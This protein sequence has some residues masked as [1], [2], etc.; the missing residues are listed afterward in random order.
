[1]EV[2]GFLVELIFNLIPIYP[3]LIPRTNQEHMCTISLSQPSIV[4]AQENKREN[5]YSS[6]KE[7][8]ISKVFRTWLST[9]KPHSKSLNPYARSRMST[10]F[11]YIL[12]NDSQ[13][14]L[15]VV[16]H[17]NLMSMYPPS[18]RESLSLESAKNR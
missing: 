9:L 10:S 18:F 16:F 3:T 8:L 5:L 7:I 11:P 14:Q 4:I 15:F 17:Y 2:A 13:E 6:S 12:P 1:M